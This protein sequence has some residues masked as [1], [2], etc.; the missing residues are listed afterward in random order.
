MV[1]LLGRTDTFCGVTVMVPGEI[2]EAG[3]WLTDLPPSARQSWLALSVAAVALVAFGVVAPFSG[4]PLAQLNAF[5]P[6]LDAIVFVSDLITSVLLFAQFSISSSRSLLAV[7][8][9]YL[10]SALIVRSA[11]ADVLRRV[12]S[13]RTPRCWYSNRIVALYLLASSGLTLTFPSLV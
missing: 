2:G 10:F 9:G 6:S 11:R 3:A 12:F 4:K 13:N 7:A 1:E 8:N 5:F